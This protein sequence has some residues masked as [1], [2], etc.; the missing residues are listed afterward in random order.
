MN[1]HRP[2]KLWGI[3]T[4]LVVLSSIFGFVL[5]DGWRKIVMLSCTAIA[6]L[7]LLLSLTYYIEFK[8]DKIIIKHGILSINRHYKSNFKAKTILIN[9]IGALSLFSNYV[10]INLKDGNTVMFN[11]KGYLDAPNIVNAFD[12]IKKEL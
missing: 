3:L 8:I 10:I 11:F 2:I 7:L 6:V 9:D 12:N 5:L 1:K 4:M